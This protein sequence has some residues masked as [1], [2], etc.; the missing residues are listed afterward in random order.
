MNLTPLHFFLAD[1][2]TDD[3]FFFKE[4]IDEIPESINL[5]T[6]F[7]GVQLM[8]LISAEETPLPDALFLDLNMPLKSGIECLTE[9]RSI[10]KF[11]GLPI[12]IYSTSLNEEVVDLLYEKGA[13]YYICKPREF[14]EIKNILSKA[15]ALLTQNKS[16]RPDRKEFILET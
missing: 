3:C 9:I 6:V 7:D 2:D 10:D 16:T 12:F 8:Q 11:E 1:D 5:T 15:V 14:G 4:A 13:S